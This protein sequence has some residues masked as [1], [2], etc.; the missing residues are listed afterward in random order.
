MHWFMKLTLDKWIDASTQ[1][2]YLKSR[3]QRAQGI[4][5]KTRY[6]HNAPTLP[7]NPIPDAPLIGPDHR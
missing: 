4:T 5:P 3:A 2:A 6:P 1:R 7:L